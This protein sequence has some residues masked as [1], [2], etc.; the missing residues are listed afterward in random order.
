MDPHIARTRIAATISVVSG[1]RVVATVLKLSSQN[2]FRHYAILHDWFDSDEVNNN[3][4]II[5][6]VLE[7]AYCP[8]ES[9]SQVA[10]QLGSEDLHAH[11]LQPVEHL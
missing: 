4:P 5:R 3:S 6:H 2:I 11:M 10:T 7:L 9:R 8:I 1:H